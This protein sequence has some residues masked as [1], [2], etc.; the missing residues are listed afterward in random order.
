LI[1][2]AQEIGLQLRYLKASSIALSKGRKADVKKELEKAEELILSPD[3][4]DNP[5]RAPAQPA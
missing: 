3:N 5:P 1:R 2:A 4:R